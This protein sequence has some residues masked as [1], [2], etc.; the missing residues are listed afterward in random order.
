MDI[1][2]S[3]GPD[4]NLFNLGPIWVSSSH[5]GRGIGSQLFNLLKEDAKMYPIA[6]LYI[7]ATPVPSTVDFYIN[8]G[9]ELL[10]EPDPILLEEEPEDI[11]L[12]FY[13]SQS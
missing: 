4:N 2:Q 13:F 1:S 10:P 8:Q 6:G 9:C 7:S 12:A 11:H 3:W 5:R